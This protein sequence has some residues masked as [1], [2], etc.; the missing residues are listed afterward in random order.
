[1]MRSVTS[2]LRCQSSATLIERKRTL[3]PSSTP[4]QRAGSRQRAHEAKRE[5]GAVHG[6]APFCWAILPRLSTHSE[7]IAW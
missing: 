2:N 6:V 1:M 5:V 4:R 7:G 3:T